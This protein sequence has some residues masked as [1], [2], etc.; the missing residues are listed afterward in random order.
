MKDVEFKLATGATVMVTLKF[1]S[2]IAIHPSEFLRLE[3]D[4]HSKLN[5]ITKGIAK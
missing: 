1:G 4:Q 3:D 2:F 5:E